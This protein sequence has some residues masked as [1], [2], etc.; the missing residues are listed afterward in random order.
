[1][2]NAGWR[3]SARRFRAWRWAREQRDAGRQWLDARRPSP[4][5]S[6]CF[7][8]HTALY[9]RPDGHVY[10]CCATG[11]ATGRVTGEHRQTLRA[12]W[13]GAELQRQRRALE[14]GDFSLG[15][16]EC[17]A[18]IDAGGRAS[19]LAAFFDRWRFGAPYDQPLMLDFALSN[20]CNLQ[21]VMCNGDLSSTIRSNREG[22]EPLPP[23]YDD[24]FFDELAA[25]LPHVERV[26]FKGGEPFLAKENRRVW[27]LMLG[28]G[29]R[30]ST[31]IVTNGTV[32]SD[33]V[34]RY[35]QELRAEVTISIDG[36]TPEVLEAIRIGVDHDRLL[37]NIDRFAAALAEVD[38][39]LTLSFCVMPDNWHQVPDFLTFAESKGANPDLILVNAPDEWDLLKLPADELATVL[40]QLRASAPELGSDRGR[41]EWD[42]L[43]RAVEAQLRHPVRWQVAVAPAP[44]EAPVQIGERR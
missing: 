24:A 21:C 35:V 7:A 14:D 32:W 12:I 36:T 29:V 15:C 41:R 13:E 8:P 18:A 44:T 17:E 23:A 37:R 6:A 27:D 22:R 5:P 3:R 30:C 33:D 11:F 39:Q 9:F 26:Q 43:L 1:M 34:R 4:V 19:S 25:F 28:L 42:G 20:R 38:R 16:Q 40:D 10:A 31:L 2:G